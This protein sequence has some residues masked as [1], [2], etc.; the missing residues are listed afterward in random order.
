MAL[1]INADNSSYVVS[2]DSSHTLHLGG[3][4]STINK[5]GNLQIKGSGV[6]HTSAS[7][8]AA[9]Q[10]L[11]I[12]DN[13]VKNRALHLGLTDGN[14]SIQAKL[15]NGTTNKLL[16]QPSGSATEF[17]GNVSGSATTTGSFG[18]GYIDN[19]LG[20]GTTSPSYQLHTIG[21]VRH[22]AS[23]FVL[24]L[25]DSQTYSAG[26]SG[27]RV[28]LQGKDSAGNDKNFVDLIGTSR[29]ANQGEF[30]V[31]VRNS[32]G[33]L[34]Q[35]LTIDDT[36]NVG[37]GTTTPDSKLSLSATSN[38]TFEALQLKNVHGEGTTQGTVDIVGDVVASNGLTARGRIQFREATNDANVSVIAF[39]TSNNT[40]LEPTERMTIAQDGVIS[41][42]FNDT[43]DIALKENISEIPSSY[44][45]V[46]QLNP[47]KFNWKEEEEK[48]TDEQIGFI[49]QEIE[50]VYPELVRGEE[51]SKSV[52]V[53]GLVSVLTKT[54][55]ELT[56]K[57]E[58]LEDKLK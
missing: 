49:A 25:Y 44:E 6:I 14:S 19:K 21:T 30:A 23:A 41:G 39:F 35:Y 3:S 57:V 36:G 5:R 26:S 9:T 15:T 47:V 20:I 7:S 16:I 12:V 42:D 34:T 8:A 2:S 40:S 37:I 50:K 22:E 4:S 55:Q 33:N 54:V 28:R 45:R 18:A 1:G 31:K 52:N 56:K 58:E 46:K 43:S 53:V 32:S 10:D 24:N 48:G 38:T 51:G 17:G 11:L 13:T 29:G 27:A